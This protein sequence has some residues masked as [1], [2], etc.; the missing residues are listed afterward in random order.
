MTMRDSL[1]FLYNN[2]IEV[3]CEFLLQENKCELSWNYNTKKGLKGTVVNRS[4][5]SL[6]GGLPKITFTIDP[7]ETATIFFLFFNERFVV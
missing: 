4:L 6:Y 1:E 3:V 5:S 2:S 7:Y